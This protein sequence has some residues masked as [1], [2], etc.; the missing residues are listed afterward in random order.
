MNYRCLEQGGGE[1]IS[2]A[3]LA[4]LFALAMRSQT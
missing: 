3:L 1:V 2:H 4:L